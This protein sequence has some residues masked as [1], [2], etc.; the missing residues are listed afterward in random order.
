MNHIELL[1]NDVEF[2]DTFT[3]VPCCNTVNEG[4]GGCGCD[5]YVCVGD[6]C[7]CDY[8]VCSGCNVDACG[9]INY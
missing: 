4:G 6:V 9:F 7:A 2:I 1:N 3:N 8:N 5:T